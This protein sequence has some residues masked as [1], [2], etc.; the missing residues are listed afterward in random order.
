MLGIRYPILQGGMAWLGTAEL[1]SAVSE[2]GGLGIIGSGNAPPEW[3]KQQITLTREMT[4]KPF[5]VNI[6][7]MSRYAGDNLK[8]AVEE[9]VKV[10]TFGGGNPGALIPGL[11]QYNVIVIPVVSSVALARRLEKAGADCIVAEGTESGGHVG[12]TTTM[13]L[14]PQVVDAVKIPVIAAGGIADGRGLVAALALGARGI[15]MGT[16]FICSEECIAHPDFKRQIIEAN[17]RATTVTGKSIGHPARCLENRFTR[18]FS[19]KER[20]GCCPEELYELSKGKLREGVLEGS[21]NNG[22]LMAGQVSGFIRDVLP[23]KDIITSTI[24]R[25][26][27]VLTN[28]CRL[29]EGSSTD[30]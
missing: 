26:E 22:S 15:Q 4:G 9:K 19:Q 10:I 7:L 13:A 27:E 18:D 14:V 5:G 11:K 16:R 21:I 29:T 23:V 12:E 1:V 24:S 28:L 3:L 8:L 17:D 25:A 2:A 6:M 30:G 20:E